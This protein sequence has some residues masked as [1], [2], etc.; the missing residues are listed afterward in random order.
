MISWLFAGL[1]NLKLSHS[2]ASSGELLECIGRLTNLL[3]LYI[4]QLPM[5]RMQPCLQ[6]FCKLKNVRGWADAMC[7]VNPG[8]YTC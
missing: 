5:P 7:T 4:G 3:V 8:L 1:Q 2:I 6:T